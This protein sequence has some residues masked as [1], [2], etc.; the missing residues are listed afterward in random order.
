ME[1]TTPAESKAFLIASFVI[2]LKVIRLTSLNSE[3]SSANLQ[4]MNSPSL[5]GSVAIKTLSTFFLRESDK[6]RLMWLSERGVQL[7]EGSGSFDFLLG[8]T[9]LLPSLP[10]F[11][12]S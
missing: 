2:S 9:A 5:S 1:S 4:A 7:H 11:G 12:K 3:N 8:Y 10:E 6:I